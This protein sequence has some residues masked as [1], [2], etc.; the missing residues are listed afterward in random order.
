MYLDVVNSRL[1][2]DGVIPSIQVSATK[3]NSYAA[4]C[5]C[6]WHTF[7][8]YDVYCIHNAVVYTRVSHAVW[9]VH[10]VHIVSQRVWSCNALISRHTWRPCS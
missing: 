5:V 8:L 9:T 7:T 4:V 10:C 6:I 2:H 3:S 1:W